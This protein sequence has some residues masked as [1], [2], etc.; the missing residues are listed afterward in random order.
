MPLFVPL[1]PEQFTHP[2]P[3]NGM[4]HATKTAVP[5]LGPQLE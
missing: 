1:S 4:D 3:L 5:L 2:H